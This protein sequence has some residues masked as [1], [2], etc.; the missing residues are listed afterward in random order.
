MELFLH[1]V[2]LG[3]TLSKYRRGQATSLQHGSDTVV[4]QIEAGME[5]LY[6]FALLLGPG[7]LHYNVFTRT[8][9]GR[10]CFSRQFE[11]H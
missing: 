6:Y 2:R 8:E 10:H 9:A 4:Q 1:L 7:G 3:G 11:R 5:K